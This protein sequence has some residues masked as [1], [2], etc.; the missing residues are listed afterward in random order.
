MG[1][2]STLAQP[3]GRMRLDNGQSIGYIHRTCSVIIHSTHASEELSLV[4][5]RLQ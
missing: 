3:A 5:F 1:V 2:A 4:N